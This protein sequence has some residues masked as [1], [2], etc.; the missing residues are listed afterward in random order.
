MV[1]ES[2]TQSVTNA[3][4]EAV[5]FLIFK[6]EEREKERSLGTG[7]DAGEPVHFLLLHTVILSDSVQ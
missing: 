2:S 3:H 5:L 1:G 7:D 4:S 6:G